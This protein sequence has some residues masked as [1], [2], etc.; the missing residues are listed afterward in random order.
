MTL[1][2]CCRRFVLV[3]GRSSAAASGAFSC[4]NR[5]LLLSSFASLTPHLLSPRTLLFANRQPTPLTPSTYGQIVSISFDC[6]MATSSVPPASCPCCSFVRDDLF[7]PRNY[8]DQDQS[9]IDASGIS[10]KNV[11]QLTDVVS[12]VDAWKIISRNKTDH[13]VLLVDTHGHPHLERGIQYADTGESTNE[14]EIIRNTPTASLN[15]GVVSLT[16]AVSPFDWNDALKYA[17]QSPFNLPALGIHPWL[18]T[19]ILYMFRWNESNLF[20]MYS[21]G[22]SVTSSLK[23]TRLMTLNN[24]CGG[25]G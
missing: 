6:T 14:P 11:V 22:I 1:S 24:I 15:K 20:S 25:I 8:Q 4:L 13:R 19:V 23:T 21:L 5:R 2:T 17:A 9:N 7:L 18:D 12:P 10:D 16:C 3:V